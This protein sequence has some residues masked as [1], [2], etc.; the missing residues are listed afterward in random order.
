MSELTGGLVSVIIPNYN[1]A[2][3]LKETVESALS[4]TYS[5]IEVIVV[6]DGSTDNSLEVLAQ[7]AKDILL[8][9][10]ECRKQVVSI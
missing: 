2:H 7:F 8:I 5:N 4:Q 10:L 1:Y 6:D 3:F 9:I